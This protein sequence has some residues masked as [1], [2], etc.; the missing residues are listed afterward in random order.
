MK[1]FFQERCGDGE[2]AA[3]DVVDQDGDREKESDAEERRR[4][5][6]RCAALEAMQ[7]TARPAMDSSGDSGLESFRFIG[8][9]RRVHR[10]VE[11]DE[12]DVVVLAALSVPGPVRKVGEKRSGKSVG[13]HGEMRFQKFLDAGL[14][15]LFVRSVHGL[16]GAVGVE[17]EPVAGAKGNFD[18]RS[19]GLRRTCRGSGRF[20]RR[21]GRCRRRARRA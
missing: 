5:F 17:E 1:I 2:R 14:A 15:V 12:G 10:E 8:N 19:T 13:R 18:G 4:K 3:I 21:G 7:V 11:N 9:C 16:E 6:R 20:L